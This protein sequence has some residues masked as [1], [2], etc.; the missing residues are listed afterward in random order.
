MIVP[1][2]V[3]WMHKID[4]IELVTQWLDF[5]NAGREHT[6]DI[7]RMLGQRLATTERMH[8]QELLA[9]QTAAAAKLLVHARDTTDFY[10]NRLPA[11]LPTMEASLWADIPILTR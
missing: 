5:Q 10:R 8:A 11:S 6:P 3:K 4:Q 2:E 9:Y 1:D 7:L